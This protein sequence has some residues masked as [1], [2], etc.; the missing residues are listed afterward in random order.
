MLLSTALQLLW[1][2]LHIAIQ[3]ILIIIN[4]LPYTKTKSEPND[5]VNQIKP[6][7]KFRPKYKK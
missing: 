1:C 7:I 3:F 4:K 2:T 5:S 6:R